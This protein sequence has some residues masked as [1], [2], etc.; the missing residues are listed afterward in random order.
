MMTS[1]T[2][3][4][5]AEIVHWALTFFFMLFAINRIRSVIELIRT[6]FSVPPEEKSEK[7]YRLYG[8]ELFI[9]FVAIAVMT[10][11]NGGFSWL[12]YP[13]FSAVLGKYFLYAGL[14]LIALLIAGWLAQKYGVPRISVSAVGSV[15][16][17][18]FIVGLGTI[19]LIE[20][21]RHHSGVLEDPAS[22][23]LDEIVQQLT[24]NTYVPN[25]DSSDARVMNAFTDD[26]LQ[27]T[28][29]NC[30]GTPAA[31]ERVSYGPFERSA[32]ILKEPKDRFPHTSLLYSFDNCWVAVE[33]HFYYDSE[34]GELGLLRTKVN[35]H[36][37]YTHDR[38]DYRQ[39][40]G[41]SQARRSLY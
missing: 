34:T 8:Y 7:F 1:I 41:K 28:T 40:S 13:G 36:A 33:A 14:L 2:E 25:P 4:Q 18:L 27:Y 20:L 16:A 26:W 31:V 21:H 11:I 5:H 17:T 12:F 32:W 9:V 6:S 10:Y 19:Y 3:L 38:K 35:D 29:D 30:G 22:Q 24:S 15:I 39:F 37:H 23:R